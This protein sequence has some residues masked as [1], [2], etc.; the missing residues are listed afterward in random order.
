MRIDSAIEGLEAKQKEL[1]DVIEVIVRLESLLSR[2]AD[3]VNTLRVE[4]ANTCDRS[5]ERKL[6]DTKQELIEYID[7]RFSWPMREI[8]KLGI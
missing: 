3:E 8:K 1:Q 2:F 6:S 5:P 7:H 4:I